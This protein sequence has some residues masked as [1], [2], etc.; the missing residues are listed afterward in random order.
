MKLELDMN[1]NSLFPDVLHRLWNNW[2]ILTGESVQ[3][4]QTYITMCF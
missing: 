3:Y 2:R 1:V 4:I